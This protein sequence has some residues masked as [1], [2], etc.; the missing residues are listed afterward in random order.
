MRTINRD[1]SGIMFIGIVAGKD[2][3]PGVRYIHESDDFDAAKERVGDDPNQR[4]KQSPQLQRA[5]Q[6]LPQSSL[7][8]AAPPLSYT[9]QD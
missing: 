9:R 1:R 8:G 6:R 5:P 4:D 3:R 2:R 7:C